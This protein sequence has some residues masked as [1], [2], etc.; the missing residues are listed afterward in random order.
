MLRKDSPTAQL[1]YYEDVHG[2]L[3]LIAPSIH[4]ERRRPEETAL[5]RIVQENIE[6]FYAQ[7]EA[8]S[9]ASLPAFQAKVCFIGA[10]L[11]TRKTP[12]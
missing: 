12:L 5:Y 7:V 8:E 6:T 4:Y 2:E 3:T 10:I 11:W 1:R 9:G